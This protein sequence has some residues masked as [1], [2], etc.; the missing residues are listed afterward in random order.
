M[1]LNHSF[2]SGIQTLFRVVQTL[3]SSIWETIIL[4]KR[5]KLVSGRIED[6]T[7]KFK[8]RNLL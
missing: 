6:S 1:Q 5:G 4:L 3:N 7:E 2:K 8:K